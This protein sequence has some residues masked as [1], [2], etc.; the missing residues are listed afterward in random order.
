[1]RSGQRTDLR[2]VALRMMAMY[3]AARHSLRPSFDLKASRDLL[4]YGFGHSLG[5]IGAVISQ[6]GDNF[7]VG[8]L[9]GSAALGLYGRAYSLMVMPA[10]IQEKYPPRLIRQVVGGV[11]VRCSSGIRCGL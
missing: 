7:C 8:R 9:L 4:S 6:Q 1:M 3:A 2:Q 11:D 5:Q 10:A